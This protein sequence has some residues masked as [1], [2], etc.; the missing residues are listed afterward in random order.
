[1]KRKPQRVPDFSTAKRPVKGEK[2]APASLPTEKPAPVAARTSVKP[3]ATTSKS[4][5]RGK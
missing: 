2:G 4:G 5:H 1:M 3:P